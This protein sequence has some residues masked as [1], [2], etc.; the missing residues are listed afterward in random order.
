LLLDYIVLKYLPSGYN[1]Y[2]SSWLL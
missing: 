2:Q 1:V